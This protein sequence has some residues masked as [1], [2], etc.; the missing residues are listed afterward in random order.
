MISQTPLVL[1]SSS[2]RAKVVKIWIMRTNL[3]AAQGAELLTSVAVNNGFIRRDKPV[4]GATLTSWTMG[5]VETPLW[6]AKAALLML[7]ESEWMPS[8]DEEWSGFA[9]IFL[10]M[11]KS[12]QLTDLL[13]QLPQHIADHIAVT[14]W[15]CAAIEEMERFNIVKWYEKKLGKLA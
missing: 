2:F 3:S 13:I 5:K 15:L 4:F 11:S 10:T 12:T 1:M 8:N 9:T 14:G 6:A 7:L